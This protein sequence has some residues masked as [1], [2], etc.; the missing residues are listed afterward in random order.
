MGVR[1]RAPPLGAFCFAHGC[2]FCFLFLHVVASLL[3][4][5]GAR[6]S[7]WLFCAFRMA[8]FL[9]FCFYKLLRACVLAWCY[10]GRAGPRV[11]FWLFKWLYACFF[12]FTYCCV[13][14]GAAGAGRAPGS[15]I[16]LLS[17][18]ARDGA[19]STGGDPQL[20]S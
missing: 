3:G 4:A 8:A 11:A 12:A 5:I 19:M 16:A 7:S 1:G 14:C 10:G 17:C 13:L 15:L 9:H 2:M 18:F 20:A 6:G